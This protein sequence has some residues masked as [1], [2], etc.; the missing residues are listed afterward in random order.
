MRLE[1]RL[2][3][4]SQRA[5]AEGRQAAPVVQLA[6]PGERLHRDGDDRPLVLVGRRHPA[7]DARPAAEGDEGGAEAARPIQQSSDR[8]PRRVVAPPRRGRGRA[9]RSGAR[10]SRGGSGRG[11]G[12]CD[13]PDRS[14]ARR[15]PRAAMAS[16]PP[17]PRPALASRGGVPGPISAS[18][19][20]LAAAGIVGRLAS[21]SSQPF[22]RRLPTTPMVPHRE[23]RR[24]IVVATLL[25]TT[26]TS[27]P[28]DREPSMIRFTLRARERA[29]P[30]ER[31][32]T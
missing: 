3:I 13:R 17:R 8:R 25:S 19:R 22:Q 16:G 18:R 27:A 15:R 26:Y 9:G 28:P 11:H 14:R 12:G 31:Q 6:N 21:S 2:E 4:R 10:S 32:T 20:R 5:R 29:F 24:P 1:R 23:L 7:D 30:A